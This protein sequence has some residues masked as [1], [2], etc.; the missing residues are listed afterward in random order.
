MVN[1]SSQ[2]GLQGLFSKWKSVF[3]K[4][5][6]ICVSKMIGSVL[7]LGRIIDDKL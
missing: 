1:G 4:N 2:F 7:S 5:T 3:I 6:F